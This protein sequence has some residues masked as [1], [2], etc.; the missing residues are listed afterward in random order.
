MPSH[1]D[2]GI[3]PENYFGGTP[4]DDRPDGRPIP[5]NPWEDPNVKQALQDGR[6]PNDIMLCQCLKCH[7]Y[8]YYNQ[9]SH[10]TCYWCNWSVSGRRLDSLLVDGECLSLEEYDEMQTDSGIP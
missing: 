8:S 7:G 4:D 6:E 9:G 2:Y 1:H 5:A 10:F 3:D